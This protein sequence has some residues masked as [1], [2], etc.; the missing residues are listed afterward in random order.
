MFAAA[1]KLEAKLLTP[2][3]DDSR[4]GNHPERDILLTQQVR[5]GVL[6]WKKASG[7]HMRSLVEN[8]FSVTKTQMGNRLRSRRDQSKDIELEIMLRHYNHTRTAGLT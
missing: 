8:A 1:A 6:W 7:Y 5:R 4:Y 3:R 2:L